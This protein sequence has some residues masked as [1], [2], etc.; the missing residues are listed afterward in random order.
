[1]VLHIGW[2]KWFFSFDGTNSLPCSLED[3]VYD[4]IDLKGQQIN[5][6]INNLLQITWWY[7][8][9]GFDFN[10]DSCLQLW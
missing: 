9:I 5:A 2:Y 6:G 7:P 8:K 1:M 4:N 10:K 3:D